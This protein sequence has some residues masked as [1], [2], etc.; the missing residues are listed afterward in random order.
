MSVCFIACTALYY[1]GYTERTTEDGQQTNRTDMSDDY[2]YTSQS[3]GGTNHSYASS[4]GGGGLDSPDGPANKPTPNNGGN[5]RPN[6]GSPL[7]KGAAG[8]SPGYIDSARSQDATE[9]VEVSELDGDDTDS[10]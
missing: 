7:S 6:R 5:R 2:S 4:R 3:S 1:T 9:S 8:S 10:F